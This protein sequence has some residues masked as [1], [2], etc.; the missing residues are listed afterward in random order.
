LKPFI[1]WQGF[2]E[3]MKD[4]LKWV[5][6]RRAEEERSRRQYEQGSGDYLKLR[7]KLFSQKTVDEL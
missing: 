4:S 1:R 6:N 7:E 5:W 2:S 3:E